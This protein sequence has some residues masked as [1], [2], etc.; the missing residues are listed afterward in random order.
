MS[1]AASESASAE[2][3]SSHGHESDHDSSGDESE[4]FGSFSQVQ[5]LKV[6]SETAAAESSAA[7][8]AISPPAEVITGN[9]MPPKS[10]LEDLRFKIACMPVLRLK[11]CPVTLQSSV[12]AY[13]CCCI[14]S[15]GYFHV[16]HYSTMIMLNTLVPDAQDQ[17]QPSRFFTLQPE[18]RIDPQRFVTMFYL[19]VQRLSFALF[20][21]L[22]SGLALCYYEPVKHTDFPSQ[23][24][25]GY[26]PLWMLSKLEADVSSA[27]PFF[28]M[29]YGSDAFTFKGAFRTHS[30]EFFASFVILWPFAARKRYP[31]AARDFV[32]VQ[33]SI[34]SSCRKL[35][36]F[37]IFEQE[38]L[39]RS[40]LAQKSG[41]MTGAR[42]PLGRHCSQQSLDAIH[43]ILPLPLPDCFLSDSVFCSVPF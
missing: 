4:M 8:P 24:A 27:T 5:V 19:S 6:E 29:Q 37:L 40:D 39:R 3:S 36:A 42:S 17:E 12:V 38:L 20:F 10:A 18:A 21:K 33:Y 2:L 28:S 35:K 25:K 22:I 11:V 23:K 13:S 9:V 34:Q 43:S 15:M 30:S 41:I 31:D 16:S 7:P 1:S 32:T 26:L 14:C